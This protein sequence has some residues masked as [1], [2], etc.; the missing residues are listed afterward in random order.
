M[1]LA[2]FACPQQKNKFTKLCMEKQVQVISQMDGSEVLPATAV[3][4]S[5]KLPGEVVT[6]KP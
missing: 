1:Y 6:K 2:F 5:E 4:Q 3:K